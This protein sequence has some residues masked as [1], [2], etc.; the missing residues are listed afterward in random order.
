MLNSTDANSRGQRAEHPAAAG[1]S[2]QSNEEFLRSYDTITGL[3][4]QGEFEAA[5]AAAHTLAERWPEKAGAS[6]LL[7]QGEAECGNPDGALE[8]L[9]KTAMRF[10]P[11]PLPWLWLARLYA[12]TRR[13]EGVQQAL[14]RARELGASD[15]ECR[16]VESVLSGALS[17]PSQIAAVEADL[18]VQGPP[19]R[20][21]IDG[22][23][24]FSELRVA[25]AVGGADAVLVFEG[26]RDN[27]LWLDRYLAARNLTAVYCR[28]SSRR[29]FVAGIPSIA[30]GEDGL[31]STL[32]TVLEQHRARR[33]ITLGNSAGGYTAIRMGLML[34]ARAVLAFGA[35]TNLG[36]RFMEQIGDRRARPALRRV[37][38]TLPDEELDL[39]PLLTSASPPVPVHLHYGEHAREDRLHAEYVA[40]LPGVHLHPQEGSSDH[41]ALRW[42][43]AER[44]FA[45]CLDGLLS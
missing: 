14:A 12:Q 8:I 15:V 33:V 19:A 24:R 27:S 2:E 40:G 41:A 43:M 30:G 29:A 22:E 10:E 31:L 44:R 28:D 16:S 37:G 18:E 7:A 35:P 42:L 20:P 5:R 36:A 3:L 9:R 6:W 45:D 4:A 1:G 21:L 13:A 38:R 25:P 26:L 23:S 39:K 32:R 34:R 17:S 11:S